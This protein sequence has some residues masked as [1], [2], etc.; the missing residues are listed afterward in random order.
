[1]TSAAAIPIEVEAIRRSTN[2]HE[3]EGIVKRGLRSAHETAEAL[4]RI[5]DAG[6]YK[7]THS[8]WESYCRTL[9]LS[10]SRAYQLM[11]FARILHSVGSHVPNEAV[12]REL[13]KAPAEQRQSVLF[14]ATEAAGTE[15]V[16]A[17]LVR[18]VVE[19]RTDG[20]AKVPSIQERRTPR[21]LFDFLDARF[22]PFVLDAYAEEHNALCDHFFDAK[23]DGHTAQ[24]EDATFANPPFEDMRP[25]FAQA[26]RMAEEGIRSC[27]VSP[28]GCSQAWYHE[29]AILGTVWCP[30]RRI[31]FDLPDGTPTKAADRDTI[32]VTFGPG[33]ENDDSVDGV[34]R[35]LQLELPE[36]PR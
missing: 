17:P 35:V 23:D 12:A 2:L 34:F 27:I 21:W 20:K 25:V 28:V 9:D 30:D 5:H 31:N 14:E 1:M 24:W 33:H 11:S 15:P 6:L 7:L 8:S 26:V 13:M 3:L 32:I 22:G 18:E 36:A 29:L 10:P 19:R 16:T 4:L